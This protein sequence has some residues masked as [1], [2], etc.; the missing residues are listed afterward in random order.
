MLERIDAQY[1]RMGKFEAQ[2]MKDQNSL[3]GSW[4]SYDLASGQ[5]LV[6][7]LVM[8]RPAREATQ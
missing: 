7:A 5:P 1:G 2:L 4:Y 8:E 6:G 3:K